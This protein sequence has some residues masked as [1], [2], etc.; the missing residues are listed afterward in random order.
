MPHDGR[1]REPVVLG[2]DFG[3][4][5]VALGVCDRDGRRLAAEVLE[6]RPDDGAP[7][8][9]DRALRAAAELLAGL[10]SARLESVGVSTIGVPTSDRVLLAPA[11]EG[12]EDVQLHRLVSAAFPDAAVA[13]L[14]DVKAAAWA[15]S[16]WGALAGA[17]P[18][19]YLNLGT[20]LA[21]ATVIG[22][23]VVLGRNGAAGEIGYNLLSASDVGIP[24]DRRAILEDRVSGRALGLR[25]GS[26]A[27]SEAAEVIRLAAS[28]DE[29]AGELVDAMTTE[30]SFH[31]VNLCLAV[32]PERVAVGGGLVGGWA[33]IEPGLRRALET[34][35]PFPPEL[36]PGRF[37]FDAP[38]LGALAAGFDAVAGAG[39]PVDLSGW[40]EG[41]LSDPTP[42]RPDHRGVDQSAATADVPVRGQVKEMA[43]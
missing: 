30:L 1:W 36:V 21:A 39:T 37:P 28:G 2:V 34:G 6:T 41:R 26:G 14:T 35:V 31:L 25:H 12:W 3:G 33:L 4:T 10:P 40:A 15:E 43:P 27:E 18:G 22:G 8:V 16:R 29:A 11:I 9:L 32:D 20:G 38:L 5:K 7:V 13:I 24:L 17:D 19:L 42:D 23:E